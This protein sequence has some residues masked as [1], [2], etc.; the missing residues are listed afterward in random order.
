[1]V[2]AIATI[3]NKKGL[4]ARAAAKVVK[5]ASQYD[6]KV[7]ITRMPRASER[8]D[9]PLPTAGGTSVLSLLMLAAE[10]GLSVKVEAEGPQ[11]AEALS[12]VV[13]LIERRFD[14]DE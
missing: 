2:S 14:E 13:S 7:Q 8:L 3:C 9:E 10:I 4:H 6:A 12:A 11:A 5:T 1:M